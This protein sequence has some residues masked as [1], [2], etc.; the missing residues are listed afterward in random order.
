M[1]YNTIIFGS[2]YHGRMALRKCSKKKSNYKVLCFID[3]DKKKHNKFCLKKKIFG[4]NRIKKIDYEKIIF[5]GRHIKN[6]LLQLKKFKVEKSKFIFWG[7]KELRL[8][9]SEL[10]Q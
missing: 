4:V 7:K 5:C 10:K 3:N 6:Q 9:K 2:G 8:N 1:K